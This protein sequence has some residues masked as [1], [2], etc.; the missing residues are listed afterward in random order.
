M[1]KHE[2]FDLLGFVVQDRVTKMVG[3]ATSLTF[4]LYGCVQMLVY[5]QADESGKV[6][7]PYWFDLNR[8]QKTSPS[9]VMEPVGWV[10]NY[11]YQE[12]PGPEKKPIR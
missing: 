9:R 3:V 11:D 5:P 4:D 6:G 1:M 7:E 12:V 10:S 2:G 8:L